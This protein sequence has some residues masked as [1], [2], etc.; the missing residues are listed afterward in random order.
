MKPLF[1]LHYMI[2]ILFYTILKLS[3]SVRVCENILYVEKKNWFSVIMFSLIE[4]QWKLHSR[5][6]C[7]KMR[8]RLVKGKLKIYININKFYWT[9]HVFH[10]SQHSTGTYMP[11]EQQRARDQDKNYHYTRGWVILV[12]N[13]RVIY[14]GLWVEIYTLKYIC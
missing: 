8:K 2:F 3:N 11:L 9:W 10:F 6:N 7:S 1:A 5:E 14:V 4:L 12:K 13:Y